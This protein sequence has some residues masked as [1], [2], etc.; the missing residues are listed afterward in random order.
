MVSFGLQD[1]FCAF[2]EMSDMVVNIFSKASSSKRNILYGGID[3][4]SHYDLGCHELSA[5]C[6]S[7]DF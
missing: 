7:K 5:V 4:M 6:T 3:E 2:Q 1:L